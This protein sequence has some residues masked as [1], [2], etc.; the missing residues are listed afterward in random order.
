MIFRQLIDNR[1]STFTYLLADEATRDAVLIDCVFEQHLRDAALI[2]ELGLTLNMTLETHVH[3]DHVTG[4]W[5]MRRDLGSRIAVAKA[6]NTDGADRLLEPGD[7]LSLGELRIEVRATPGHTDGCL[8]FVLHDQKMVFTGDALLIRGAGRTDFQQGSPERLFRSVRNEL[9]SLPE[10][11][12]VYPGHD[13]SGRCSSTVGEERHFNPRLGDGVRVEDFVGYMNNLG[14]PHPKQLAVAVPAN[15]RC[16]QPDNA[17]ALPVL[18]SWGP[19]VRTFAGVWQVDPEW[20]YS[21]LDRVHL[22]DVR[23]ADEV[24]ADRMG[25]I[26][27]AQLMPLSTLRDEAKSLSPD[28]PIV[29]VCPA[30]ARSAIAASIIE[31]AGISRVA[32]LR[33]GLFEWKGL[34]LPTL[35]ITPSSI[36][37]E[38]IASTRDHHDVD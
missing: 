10:D 16:G 34:G 37:D 2:R 20:V 22:I 25:R 33:G 35:A 11:Y 21:N 4:A 38:P 17:A 28:K 24:Q 6:A 1:T 7:V 30:G 13:Y 8:S 18:P 3:A 14:L 36:A 26:A 32:N 5:L 15:L 19:V 12:S 9:L 31:A 29:T 27:G 23:E